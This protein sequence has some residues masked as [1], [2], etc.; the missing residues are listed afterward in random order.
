MSMLIKYLLLFVLLAVALYVTFLE[1]YPL[2]DTT[3]NQPLKTKILLALG[4]SAIA[5]LL[6]WFLAPYL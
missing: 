5:L 3:T 1:V 2:F 4:T 6:Y